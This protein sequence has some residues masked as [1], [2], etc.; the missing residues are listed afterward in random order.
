MKKNK[1]LYMTL[2][3]VLIVLMT[4]GT[5]LINTNRV[6]ADANAKSNLSGDASIPVSAITLGAGQLED[7]IFAIGS[8][9]PSAT[10][11]VNSKVAGEVEKVYFN[12]GDT[13]KKDDILFTLK[14]D[15]FNSDKTSKVQS[16]K[17]QMDLA[18]ISYD[19]STKTYNDTKL[20]FESGAVSSDQLDQA[21]LGYKNA[22]ASYQSASLNYT[23]TVSGL[24][25]QSDFYAVKSPV[26]GL[27]TSKNIEKGMFASSQNGFTIIVDDSLKIDATVASKYIS[28]VAVGQP[29]DIYVNT[30]NKHFKGELTSISYAAEK[31]SYPVEIMFTETDETIYSGM[32]AELIIEI[33]HEEDVL[34]LPIE[35]IMRE[36]NTSYIFKSVDGIAVKTP[37]ST[38]IRS[39]KMIEVEGDLLV[40][41]TIIVEGKE[42]I[43]D[44]IKVMV[45]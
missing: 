26:D 11:T 4:A 18:K 21:A 24:N 41:D 20:L 19:Q 9:Q 42:F 10:Y 22:Q 40:G 35:A 33:A 43:R 23:A 13:V 44:G 2:A 8:I 29:V 6:T 15:T 14:D 28:Q 17:N 16:L 31:G 32:Y 39:N 3:A 45:K 37:V 38:G 1:K 5:L 12:I 34:L 27:I 25:D 36:E 7:T 30:L